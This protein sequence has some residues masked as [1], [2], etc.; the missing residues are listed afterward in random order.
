MKE[1]F[2]HHI[3]KFKKFHFLNLRTVQGEKLTILNSGQ[4]LGE[5]G[6][7]FFNGQII[8]DNQKWAGNIEMHLKSSDWYMHHHQ[9]DASYQNVILHVVWQHDAEIYRQNNTVIPTL[10]IRHYVDPNTLARYQEL[11]RPKSWVYCENQLKDVDSFIIA[12][13]FERIFMERLQR[14]SQPVLELL[15]RKQSDWEAV[16]F[17]LLSTNFGLNTN[18]ETF[19]NVAESIPFAVV[20]K[21]SSDQQNLEALLFG[22]AGLLESTQEDNYFKELKF[23]YH[24]L[25]QKYK[26]DQPILPEMQFFKLRPDNFPT[27]RLSQLA[28]CYHQQHHLFS[29]LLNSKKVNDL[30]AIFDVVPSP[31]WQTHYTFDHASIK[32]RKQLSKSFIQLLIINTIIPLKFAYF[33][34]QNKDGIDD[35]MALM[36]ELPPERNAV[37]DK[38]KTFDIVARNTFESQALLQLKKEYCDK[39]RCLDCQIG[40]AIL[41]NGSDDSVSN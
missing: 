8:I 11:A 41:K 17:C 29:Q 2:L 25:V 38:F 22:T 24:Y 13:W 40:S 14:K 26:L 27:V 32:K 21:E 10:E 18:G 23:R 31:Y 9:T 12:N 39:R 34:N 36:R 19:M 6:P 30:Y 7:D 37:I 16:L 4:Y 28:A 3:W 35:L 20:R 15:G 1:D 5:S 33:K